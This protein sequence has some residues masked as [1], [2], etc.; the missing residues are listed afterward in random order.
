MR[1]LLSI[2]F[3]LAFV[4][5]SKSANTFGDSHKINSVWISGKVYYDTVSLES[6][7]CDAQDLNDFNGPDLCDENTKPLI[8]PATYKVK[9]V[10]KILPVIF[11][12]SL[13]Y[14][15]IDLPPPLFSKS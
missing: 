2:L 11:T 8:Q 14:S 1:V 10:S 12:I 9:S 3:V 13:Q 15:L 7:I 4:I 5:E 6:G